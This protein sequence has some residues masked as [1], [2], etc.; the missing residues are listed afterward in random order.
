MPFLADYCA[1]LSLYINGL[2]P[3]GV[4]VTP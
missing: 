1:A 3:A 4:L 2:E